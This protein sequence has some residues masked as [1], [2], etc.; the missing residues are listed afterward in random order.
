M[1]FGF[2]NWRKLGWP[3]IL[4]VSALTRKLLFRMKIQRSFTAMNGQLEQQQGEIAMLGGR[5][6]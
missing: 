3:F 4:S 1:E 5:W 6:K 2:F